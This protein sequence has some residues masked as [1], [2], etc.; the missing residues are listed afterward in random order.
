ML[1]QPAAAVTSSGTA[2]SRILFTAVSSG[3]TCS[4]SCLAVVWPSWSVDEESSATVCCGLVCW[5]CLLRLPPTGTTRRWLL[6]VLCW[7]Y[8]WEH[9]GQLFIQWP[10]FGSSR[11]IDRSSWRIWWLRRWERLWLFP[12]VDFWSR[13]WDGKVFSILPVSKLYIYKL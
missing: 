9:R 13:F 2:S 1:Q 8:S 6:C 5:R 12:F 4:P 11:W 3:V 7:V 10:P